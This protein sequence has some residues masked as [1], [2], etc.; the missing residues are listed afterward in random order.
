V[1]DSKS[2]TDKPCSDYQLVWTR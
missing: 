1:K 2:L